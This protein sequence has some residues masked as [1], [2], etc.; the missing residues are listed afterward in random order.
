LIIKNTKA[1]GTFIMKGALLNK[2]NNN[3][4]AIK[5]LDEN[6]FI[7]HYRMLSPLFFWKELKNRLNY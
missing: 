4:R 7:G 1:D 2:D 6:W 3:N 5:S